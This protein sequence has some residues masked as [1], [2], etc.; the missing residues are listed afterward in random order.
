M[1][2]KKNIPSNLNYGMLT[3]SIIV[4]IIFSYFIL[5]ILR[6]S[7]N[8]WYFLFGV[9][10]LIVAIVGA[11]IAKGNKKFGLVAGL[12]STTFLLIFAVIE[13]DIALP[14]ICVLGLL[15]GFIGN[16]L[17]TRIKHF[18]MVFIIIII[19][20][21]LILFFYGPHVIVSAA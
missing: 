13:I 19:I 5:L 17:S 10:A 11:A 20:V 8:S 21:F 12:L 2:I 3:L 14:I 7:S 4:G 18:S 1:V 6:F 9:D 15:G 16:Y